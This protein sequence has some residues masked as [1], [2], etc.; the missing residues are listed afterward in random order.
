MSPTSFVVWMCRKDGD[1][2]GRAY[3]KIISKRCVSV[4]VGKETCRAPYLISS[5]CSNFKEYVGYWCKQFGSFSTLRFM[6]LKGEASLLRVLGRC[7]SAYIIARDSGII[8]DGEY[9]DLEDDDFACLDF[10]SESDNGYDSDESD[11]SDDDIKDIEKRLKFSGD[12]RLVV[13]QNGRVYHI[14]FMVSKSCENMDQYW[15]IWIHELG[16]SFD[17]DLHAVDGP[18]TLFA[19][20]EECFA[21]FKRVMAGAA[22]DNLLL[23]G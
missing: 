3:H 14:P 8:E 10:D 19:L 9:L 5:D 13:V 23:Y 16:P 20:L 4:K 1:I 18:D 22:P 21:A 7:F 11:E 15:D 2:Y 17:L 12:V 6:G